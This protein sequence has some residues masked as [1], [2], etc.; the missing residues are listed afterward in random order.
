[1]QKE[2]QL[3][4]TPDIALQEEALRRH[5]AAELHLAPSSIR[6]MRLLRKSIDARQRR[7]FV[8]LTVLLFIDEDE[9]S[10]AFEPIRYG[11]VS[12][13][14]HVIVVGA[15]PA[16]LF[17]ALHLI[18]L[19]LCP[20]LLERGKDVHE[21]RK[22]IA[23]IKQHQTVDPES[24]YSFGEGGAGAYSDGKLY[25]RSKKRGNVDKILRIF[26]QF[27]AQPSIL[28][29]AHPHIGTDRLPLIIEAMRNQIIE[30]GGEVHFQTCVDG[31][32]RQD[33]RVIG[34]RTT[35]GAEFLG[36][37]ILLRV[38]RREMS[39]AFSAAMASDSKRRASPSAF[40]SSILRNSS[41]ACNITIRKDGVNI[42]RLPNTIT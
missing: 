4:L 8:N 25:T 32:L 42:C 7:V 39:T 29:D 38:I 12:R 2:I 35:A 33:E 16:G 17:A 27:G 1:M 15:G 18:E 6:A 20:I 24:N 14:P 5:C 23:R 41:T 36:P 22:D 3:R 13:A 30:S 11:D 28:Y 9:S 34:V 40:A 10:V 31:L 26:A 37:V 21:R 19:G